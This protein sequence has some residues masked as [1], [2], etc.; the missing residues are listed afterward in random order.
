MAT[1]GFVYEFGEWGPAY[2][3]VA[4]SVTWLYP[5]QN[6]TQ[7]QQDRVRLF[8]ELLPD[9]LPCPLCGN[10]FRETTATVHPIT[11]QVL[12]SRSTLARWLVDVHNEVNRRLGKSTVTYAEAE[13]FYLRDCGRGPVPAA[14]PGRELGLIAAGLVLLAVGGLAGFFIARQDTAQPRAE[15]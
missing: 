1:R 9:L 3:R 7:Q 10:H 6:P 15:A 14:V 4:H 8:F 2:W 5:E 12:S 13:T 11:E